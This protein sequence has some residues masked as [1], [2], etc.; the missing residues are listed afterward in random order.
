MCRYLILHWIDTIVHHAKAKVTYGYILVSTFFNIFKI[1]SD[2]LVFWG[3]W[4]VFFR[5]DHLDTRFECPN[6]G[7]AFGLGQRY[8]SLR[9]I[10]TNLVAILLIF[11]SLYHICLSFA[12]TFAWLQAADPS[13]IQL[14][15]KARNAF[16]ISY[17]TMQFLGTGAMF[18]WLEFICK[19][20][21]EPYYKDYVVSLNPSFSQVLGR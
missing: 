2:V 13:V 20:K 8:E 9:Y 12:L 3:I 1:L 19:E 7:F 4:K 11:F 6:M 14:I 15:A 18:F 16:E 17:M 5:L 21:Y 10:I